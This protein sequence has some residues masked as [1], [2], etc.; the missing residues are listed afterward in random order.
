LSALE[1]TIEKGVGSRERVLAQWARIAFFD[2]RKAV[3][4]SGNAVSLEDSD[5]LDD[6]TALAISEVRQGGTACPSRPP[7]TSLR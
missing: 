2:L 3:S 6:D 5:E 4:W 1:R 7:T